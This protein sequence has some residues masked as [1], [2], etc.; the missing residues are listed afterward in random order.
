MNKG[1]VRGGM[2]ELKGEE[3]K[4]KRGVEERRGK[5]E[6]KEEEE[7]SADCIDDAHR[8]MRTLMLSHTYSISSKSV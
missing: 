6:V 5:Q 7:R 2:E 4:R 3:R 8:L 1:E